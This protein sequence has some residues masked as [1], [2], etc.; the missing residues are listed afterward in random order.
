MVAVAA[1]DDGAATDDDRGAGACEL[2]YVQV[3]EV[4]P[5]QLLMT[6]QGHR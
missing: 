6:Q 2:M 4:I 1:D 5:M 3:A